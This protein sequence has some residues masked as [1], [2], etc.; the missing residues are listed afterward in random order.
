MTLRRWMLIPLFVV[1]LS[2][3]FAVVSC[4]HPPATIITPA[5]K[6][7]YRA[8]QVVARFKELSDLVKADTG[9]APGNI[10]YTDAFTIIEWISGDAQAKPTPTTGVVQLVQTT[11][12]QGWKVAALQG[13]TT[14]VKPIFLRYPRLVPW[15]DIVDALLQVVA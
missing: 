13:W 5:G 4:I 8:D 9:T 14:R 1:T 7:A 2:A 6:D 12:G 15:V 3:D 10:S 11:A